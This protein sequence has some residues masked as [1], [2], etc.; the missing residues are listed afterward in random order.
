MSIVSRAARFFASGS[1]IGG[2]LKTVFGFEALW[3]VLIYNESVR[4]CLGEVAPC[5]AR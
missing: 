3:L 1:F 4:T 5:S 2:I